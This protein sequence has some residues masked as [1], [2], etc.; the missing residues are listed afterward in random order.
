MSS[1]QI[2]VVG[3]GTAGAASA[4]LLARAGHGVVV[5]E[6]VPDPKPVGAGI[7]LQPT[8]Q[9]QLA[10]LG[11]LEAVTA[12]SSPVD[13]LHAVRHGGRVLVDLRYHDVHPRLSGWGVHRGV[14]FETLLAATRAAGV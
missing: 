3:A 13:R 7:L 8:G 14:L 2:A 12:R 5:F 10:R 9:V 6:R 11:L 1:F 4:T